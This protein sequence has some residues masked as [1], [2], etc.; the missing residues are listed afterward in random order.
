[1]YVCSILVCIYY[2]GI[3]TYFLFRGYL[4]LPAF[5]SLRGNE[6]PLARRCQLRSSLSEVVLDVL[7]E[8]VERGLLEDVLSEGAL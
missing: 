1:M 2:Y 7:E 4:G 5:R 8:V 6:S 3:I